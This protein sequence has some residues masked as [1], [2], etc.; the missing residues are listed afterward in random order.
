MSLCFWISRP[1]SVG[2][3]P[4]VWASASTFGSISRSLATCSS[5]LYLLSRVYFATSTSYLPPMPP[6]AFTRSQKSFWASVIGT[7][8]GA[9]GPSVR[10]DSVPR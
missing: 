1:A 5:G 3:V 10:S 2:G 6:S 8:S 7:A 9:N 4:S